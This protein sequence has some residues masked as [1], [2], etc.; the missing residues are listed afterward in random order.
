MANLL[1]SV[2]DPKDIRRLTI[3]ELKQLATE[4]REEVIS[5][6]SEVGGHFAYTL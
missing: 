3:D 4:I 1:D 5:V 6:V 2:G